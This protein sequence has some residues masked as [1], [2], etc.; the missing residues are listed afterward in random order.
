MAYSEELADRVR[1]MLTE[2]IEFGER[3]MFG[4]LCLLDRGNMCCGVID[5]RLMLRVG[6]DAYER[7]LALKH[8]APMDFTGRP[9]RGLVYVEPAGLRT[10]P[11]LRRWV[12][13]ALEFTATLPDKKPAK[14]RPRRRAPPASSGS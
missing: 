12:G 7:V 14:P 8:V 5:E 4:G 6:P 2:Q 10:N 13:L 3:R 1:L 9:L 11:Q